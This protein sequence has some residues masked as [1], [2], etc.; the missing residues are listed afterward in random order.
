MK[1]RHCNRKMDF[2]EFL[3][4]PA[5][6]F[7]K[8]IAPAVIPAVIAAILR[9]LSVQNKGVIDSGMAGLANNFEIACP[10]CKKVDKPWDP[11]PEEKQKKKPKRANAII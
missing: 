7:L 2:V 6:Y 8:L 9:E 1:C 5:A 4:Y 3:T 10:E 11:A